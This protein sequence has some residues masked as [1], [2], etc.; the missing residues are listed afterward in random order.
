MAPQRIL[1]ALLLLAGCDEGGV[2][3]IVDL[4][5]DWRAGV[6]FTSVRV[7]LDGADM[8]ERAVREGDDFSMGSRVAEFKDL[9]P[10]ERRVLVQLFD[11][12]G[13]VIGQ[14]TVGFDQR[15]NRG[16]RVEI[17]RVCDGVCPD[18]D[19]GFDSDAMVEP[20]AGV[21]ATPD[22]PTVEIQPPPIPDVCRGIF[23]TPLHSVWDSHIMD[24]GTI[25]VAGRYTDAMTI[26][27]VDLPV[28][29]LGDGLV[30]A[31]DPD[32]GSVLWWVTL[33][34]PS[35]ILVYGVTSSG[36]DIYV[37]GRFG[38]SMTLGGTMLTSAGGEDVFVVRIDDTGELQGAVSFGGPGHEQV[39]FIE[40]DDA[41]NLLVG[42]SFSDTALFLDAS[43]TASG[44]TAGY[45]VRLGR[46]LDYITS[47]SFDGPGDERVDAVA[48]SGGD[49]YVAGTFDDQVMLTRPHYAVDIDLFL[50]RAS[51]SGDI[52]W[53]R[54]YGIR[55]LDDVHGVALT[56]TSVIYAG[57][58]GGFFTNGMGFVLSLD[59]E[60]GR[61]EWEFPFGVPDEENG[62]AGVVA[63]ERGIVYALTTFGSDL[64]MGPDTMRSLGARDVL[65]TAHDPEDEGRVLW[66]RHFGGPEEDLAREILL[67]VDDDLWI[68][69]G[70]DNPVDCD[71]MASATMETG[72]YVVRLSR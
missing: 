45:L 13:L 56:N 66:S 26:D 11:E 43:Y 35:S 5:T 50:A 32:D 40:T 69:F 19:G 28:P 42:G 46:D 25:L 51:F 24:D 31:H 23:R 17:G 22:A 4:Q 70:S 20:D 63:D 30:I 60:D 15:M 2:D 21:D 64:E 49:I 41:G 12:D 53:S 1:L 54:E 18:A 47:K 39:E 38:V 36:R 52:A 3:L 48:E 59:R 57:I 58:T 68:V 9:A 6:D 33:P 65:L 29:E 61:I 67:G 44:G 34:S 37:T 62:T 27:G 16:L 10:G 7:A 72:D 14:R 8:R 71:G 55:L